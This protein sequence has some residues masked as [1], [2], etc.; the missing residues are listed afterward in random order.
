MKIKAPQTAENTNVSSIIELDVEKSLVIVGKNGS[1]KSRFV[2]EIE[3]L[4]PACH[5]ISAQKSLKIPDTIPLK[6][7]DAAED[8]F[9][10]GSAENKKQNVEWRKRNYRWRNSEDMLNDYQQVLSLLF[11]K[12]NERNAIYVEQMRSSSKKL[13]IPPSAVD[14]IRDI[15]KKIFPQRSI[16][17]VAASVK[18]S[19]GNQPY[20]GNEMSDGERA[21]LYLMAE[22][23]CVPSDYI[24]IIDEPENHFHRS[25]FYKLCDEIEQARP[26]CIFIYVTHDLDFATSRN[27]ANLL[28]MNKFDGKNWFYRILDYQEAIPLDIVKEI[29]GGAEKILFIE[30][31]GTSYDQKLYGTIFPNIKIIPCGGCAEVIR[32]VKAQKKY[33][34]ISHI[35][36][37]GLIDR[38]FRPENE[39]YSL[40]KEDIF[41]VELAEIESFFIVPEIL[42]LMLERLSPVAPDEIDIRQGE[43]IQR[44]TDIF[45]GQLEKQVNAAIQTELIFQLTKKM[46]ENIDSFLQNSKKEIEKLTTVIKE[47]ISKKFQKADNDYV[48]ILR[49]FNFKATMGETEIANSLT[50]LLEIRGNYEERVINFLHDE[51]FKKQASAI[52]KNYIP[53]ELMRKIEEQPV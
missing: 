6:S 19:L 36:A 2:R 48:E 35:C 22:C 11:M 14:R 41:V 50:S 5:R 1:G 13:D 38:D 3:K 12:E 42:K 25:I 30:G 15:W 7:E 39:I 20:A 10:F 4:N 18:A 32:C 29:L 40:A 17:L 27:N 43:L 47:E 44:I 26:D 23:L 33:K 21:G 53:A 8:E 9:L 31:T 16:S 52:W 37:Y 46:K 28:C 45:K 34:H 49:I 51:E 24:V